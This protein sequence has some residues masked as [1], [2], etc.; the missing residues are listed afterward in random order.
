MRQVPYDPSLK[1]A[2]EEAE[3]IICDSLA[4]L[5]KR[6]GIKPKEVDFL[7]VNC[8][9][10]SP[11]PSLCAMAANRFKMRSDLRTFN[12]SGQGCSASLLSIDLASELL[13]N[14]RNTLAVVVSTELISKAVYLGHD[15]RDIAEI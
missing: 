3:T 9:L 15:R 11:T 13:Q 12:L 6:T 10:F 1:N 8:S 2:R 14:N 5:F 7:V 4:A